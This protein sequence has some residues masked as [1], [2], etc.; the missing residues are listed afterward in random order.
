MEPVDTEDF[1]T[2]RGAT[3]PRIGLAV[4][5]NGLSPFRSSG[6]GNVRPRSFFTAVPAGGKPNEEA[7]E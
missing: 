3:D 2:V 4:P 5:P 1:R 7:G 6:A